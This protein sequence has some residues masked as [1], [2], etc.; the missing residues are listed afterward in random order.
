ML[1]F[2]ADSVLKKHECSRAD[3]LACAR[4]VL[5][6][7]RDWEGGR[8]QRLKDAPS[9]TPPHQSGPNASNSI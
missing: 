4:D 3:V 1:L 6:G 9:P 2:P 8:K 7:A 5:K